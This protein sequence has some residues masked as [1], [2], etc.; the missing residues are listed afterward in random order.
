MNYLQ[1]E[2]MDTYLL[3]KEF[4]SIPGNRMD[5]ELQPGRI[6]STEMMHNLL[7]TA[8]KLVGSWDAGRTH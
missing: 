2:S 1:Y 5:I 3:Y 6:L 8:Y 4:K 7:I